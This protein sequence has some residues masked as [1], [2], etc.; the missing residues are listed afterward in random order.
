[1][2]AGALSVNDMLF[3]QQSQSLAAEA[4]AIFRPLKNA[5]TENRPTAFKPQATIARPI[6][7]FVVPLHAGWNI[8]GTA[9]A[10]VGLDDLKGCDFQTP[11]FGYNGASYEKNDRLALGRGYWVYVSSE[12]RLQFPPASRPLPMMQPDQP[13][14]MTD[15]GN[16]FDSGAAP[17]TNN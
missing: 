16:A 2:L 12:C 8:I 11:A 9:G 14:P 15:Q 13:T 10:D 3:D 17:V 1:M 4:G 7:N 5:R 6:T